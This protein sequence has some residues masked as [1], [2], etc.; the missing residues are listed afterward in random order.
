[1]PSTD[2]P[3]KNKVNEHNIDDILITKELQ[4]AYKESFAGDFDVQV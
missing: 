4:K 2:N 3:Y 1:V